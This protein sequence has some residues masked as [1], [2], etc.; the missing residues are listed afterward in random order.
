MLR[1]LLPAVLYTFFIDPLVDIIVAFLGLYSDPPELTLLRLIDVSK[2]IYRR[3]WIN[4][5]G[6]RGPVWYT[7]LLTIFD[8][9]A[10]LSLPMGV[11]YTRGILSRSQPFFPTLSGI[12][13]AILSSF[14]IFS[15]LTLGL[16]ARTAKSLAPVEDDETAVQSFKGGMNI[17]ALLYAIWNEASFAFITPAL[18]AVF[19]EYFDTPWTI[20]L[21]RPSIRTKAI[22]V[23]R[24]SYASFLV[25]PVVSVTVEVFLDRLM[26]CGTSKVIPV[27]ETIGAFWT[28]MG[29]GMLNVLACSIVAYGLVQ[30]V[31]LARRLI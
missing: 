8:S 16:L 3:S 9:T 5:H 31:P 2:S 22:S 13:V 23:A 10:I 15:T 19:R 26:G 28:A 20:R 29:V 18:L 11:H 7:V 1:L 12:T 24:Y 25:H 6:I 4:V 30:Y 17:P 21:K 14:A 27:G